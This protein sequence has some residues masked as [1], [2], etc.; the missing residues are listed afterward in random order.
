MRKFEIVLFDRD[1]R[2]IEQREGLIGFLLQCGL[3]VFLRRIEFS[4][5]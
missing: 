4:L 1:R 2:E 3:Q 5:R